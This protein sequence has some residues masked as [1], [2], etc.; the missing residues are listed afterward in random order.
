MNIRL[1]AELVILIRINLFSVLLTEI[2]F[3]PIVGT[4]QIFFAASA[5]LYIHMIHIL[6]LHA[7]VMDQTW[8]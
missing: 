4:F 5:S 6:H 7:G 8:T 1:R 2:L 3:I